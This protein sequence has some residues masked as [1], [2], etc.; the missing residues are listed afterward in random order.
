MTYR[1]IL[2]VDFLSEPF[3]SPVTP[4]SSDMRPYRSL[5]NDLWTNKY[6]ITNVV[7]GNADASR[8]VLSSTVKSSDLSV[9][10]TPLILVRQPLLFLGREA[11]ATR[12]TTRLA[13]LCANGAV[14]CSKRHEALLA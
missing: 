11:Q 9:F 14:G 4:C 12:E 1:A 8:S 7:A 13:S 5:Q 3:E 6:L 10:T 2:N